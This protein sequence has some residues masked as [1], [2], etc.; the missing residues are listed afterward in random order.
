MEA[1]ETVRRE[2]RIAP[3]KGKESGYELEPR[4][5]PPQL[6]A[7]ERGGDG[8]CG[9]A[10]PRRVRGRAG[11]GRRGRL[12][13][14]ERRRLARRR[15]RRGHHVRG[16]RVDAHPL[17]PELQPDVPQ[18]GLR[19]GRRR[20]SPK[21]RRR[22]RGQLR[23]PAAARLFARALPAP[24]GVQRRPHQVPDETQELAA[25]RRRGH[26][27][28]VARQGRMGAH[29]LGRRAHLRHRRAQARVRRARPGRRR[30]QRVALGSR[31]GH[32]PRHRRR[33]VRHRNRVVRLL[34][35]PDRG[36]WPVLPRRPSRPHDGPRQIRPAQRRYHRAV[37]LQPRLGTALQHVL[38][39]E[40]EGRGRRFRVRGAELQ[41]DGL[42]AGRAV[43]PRASR[44]RHG[45]SAGRGARDDPARRGT[46]R[47]H[48][49][50]LRERAHGGLH[51][52]EHAGRGDHRRELPRLRPG[53]L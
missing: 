16:G 38:A 15:V 53:R 18:H 6:P 9:S 48:R 7:G 12:A 44:H 25:R 14:G 4:H 11:R 50:G 35:L 17:P 10:R 26:A 40:R 19:R 32:V 1:S 36:A 22:A 23:L 28:R 30:V 34:G 33:G 43:D 31:F 45:V 8:R 42:C 21:D 3:K 37:R 27:R 20:H 39:H 2:S 46:R 47:H 13:A 51:A 29:Q 24:A 52:R 41:R 5:E 49:L